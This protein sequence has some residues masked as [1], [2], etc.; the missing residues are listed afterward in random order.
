MCVRATAVATI[1]S[2]TNEQHASK[3]DYLY[4]NNSKYQKHCVSVE[5]LKDK[6]KNT[7]ETREHETLIGIS[8]EWRVRVCLYLVYVVVWCS[9]INED[10]GICGMTKLHRKT[11]RENESEHDFNATKNTNDAKQMNEMICAHANAR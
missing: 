2:D 8:E 6:N 9:G 10:D 1:A 4:T 7:K 11:K 5:T 3:T